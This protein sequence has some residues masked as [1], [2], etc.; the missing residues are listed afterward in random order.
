MRR[1]LVVL[2]AA[3]ACAAPPVR[4]QLIPN[5]TPFSVEL[6]GGVGLP[7]G[8]FGEGASAGF[9]ASGSV[10]YHF[11]P[12]LGAYAGYAYNQ[13][14]AD[15]AVE[16]NFGSGT[17]T[18]RGFTLG[19]RA[20]IPT[21]LIPIDPWIRGGVVFHTLEASEFSAGDGNDDDSGVGYEVG[22]GVGLSFLPKVQLTPGIVYQWYDT[23]PFGE[24]GIVKVDVGVR[25]RI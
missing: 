23:E 4:A 10:T 1:T 24:I 16:E 9:V 20:E 12:G 8:D 21:P 22:A 19:L 3:L 2:A 6:R 7:Q 25:V 11:F 17:F 13:F 14:D 15:G 5:L 18:D